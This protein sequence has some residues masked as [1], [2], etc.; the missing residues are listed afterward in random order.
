MTFYARFAFLILALVAAMA[1]AGGTRAAQVNYGTFMGDSVTFL[2][3][4]ENGVIAVVPD[5][6]DGEIDVDIDY[7]AFIRDNLQTASTRVQGDLNGNCFIDFDDFRLHFLKKTPVTR[8][9]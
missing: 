7:Y 3:V 6:A 5:G 8:I 1:A 9:H 4:T 2:E